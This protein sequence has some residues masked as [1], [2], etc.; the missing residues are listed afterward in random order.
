MKFRPIL[1]LVT[2]ALIVLALLW[3]IYWYIG[4]IDFAGGETGIGLEILYLLVTSIVFSGPSAIAKFLLLS[5]RD[6]GF[7]K[8]A[9]PLVIVAADALATFVVTN[10]MR[11]DGWMFLTLTLIAA[12]AA[13]L[14]VWS[15]VSETLF[16]RRV[17]RS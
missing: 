17:T 10:E 14:V 13:S 7:G 3:K 6:Y 2:T 1:S 11:N 4:W 16:L 12:T 9:L 5:D 15:G 8:S